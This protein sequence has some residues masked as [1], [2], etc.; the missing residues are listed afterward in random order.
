M[1]ARGVS[2]LRLAAGSAPQAAILAF[3]MGVGAG[4]ADTPTRVS[5]VVA[6][7][8]QHGRY[9]TFGQVPP[10]PK[11]VRP[12]RA[13][14]TA[15]TA[16]LGDGKQLAEQSAAQP[17]TLAGTDDWVARARAEAAPP[18]PVTAASDPG[19]EAMVAQMRA[20]AK[21]PPRHR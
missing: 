11:D 1:N 8:P 4:H 20:R 3:V 18:P 10:A 17:W 15:V 5:A 13:W 14:K 12:T 6:N 2:F 9:P 19:L 7:A 21:E 16:V